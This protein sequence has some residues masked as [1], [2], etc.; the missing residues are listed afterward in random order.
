MTAALFG[1]LAWG[2]LT[3]WVRDRWALAVGQVGLLGLAAV[4]LLRGR[5]RWPAVLWPLAAVPVWG[6]CQLGF[7]WTED[8]WMTSEMVLCWT[9]HLAAAFVAAQA[10]VDRRWFRRLLAGFGVALAL[11]SMAQCWTAGGR[12]FWWFDSGYADRVFGPFVYHNKFAQFLELVLP[13][14]LLEGFEDRSRAGLWMAGAAV[15]FGGIV[16]SSSR[17]GLL[18]GVVELALVLAA[19]YAAGLVRGRMAMWSGASLVVLAMAGGLLAGW[20]GVLERVTG[21]DPRQDLRL[22]VWRSTIE[23]V[24]RRPWT[25]FGLG[26]FAV[27]YPAFADMDVGLAVNTA[28]QDW[29]QWAAEGGLPMLA[30]ML[31]FAGLVA[32]RLWR[33]LWGVGALV[34]LLHG[35]LDYPMHQTPAFASLVIVV[36]VLAVASDGPP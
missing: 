15:V 22:P 18:M 30:A 10:E 27:I 14:V 2:V 7:G 23:M 35:M 21:L 19:G 31:G 6:L 3:L 13:V 32:P 16:A 8:R 24:L 17:S 34:V 12:V 5:R 29:L 26:S 28:H 1:C 33:S 25:G 11:E 9:G 36:A 20:S 4:C